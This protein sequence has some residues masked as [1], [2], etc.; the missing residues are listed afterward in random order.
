[1]TQK[2]DAAIRQ[3]FT[4]EVLDTKNNR[5]GTKYNHVG[6]RTGLSSMLDSQII[7]RNAKTGVISKKN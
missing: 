6:S 7:A 2:F 4:K 1:M 5:Q 3:G